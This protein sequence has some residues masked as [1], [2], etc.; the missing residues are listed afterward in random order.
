MTSWDG[1]EIDGARKS[2]VTI[3][4]NPANGF[5][6][7]LWGW[8][9]RLGLI[10]KVSEDCLKKCYFSRDPVAERAGRAF[11]VLKTALCMAQ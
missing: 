4:Y 11:E 9:R 1:E 2:Q 10:W 3:N 7:Q 6:G 8:C 5:G